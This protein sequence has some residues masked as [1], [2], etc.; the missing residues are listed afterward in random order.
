MRKLVRVSSILIFYGSEIPFANSNRNN[1]IDSGIINAMFE[2]ILNTFT[3]LFLDLIPNIKDTINPTSIKIYKKMGI[4]RLIFGNIRP[5]K[6]KK[7]SSAT[8]NNTKVKIIV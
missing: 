1:H 6:T 8:K 7:T 5:L 3:V 4:H 2:R